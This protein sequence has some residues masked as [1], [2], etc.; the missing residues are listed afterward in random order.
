MEDWYFLTK[1]KY[2]T[3]LE[4]VWLLSIF[5]L[6]M[7]CVFYI[8]VIHDEDQILMLILYSLY[9]FASN[10]YCNRYR[11]HP[12]KIRPILDI[13][14]F[15]VMVTIKGHDFHIFYVGYY[16]EIRIF[17]TPIPNN[18]VIRDATCNRWDVEILFY[19]PTKTSI[20]KTSSFW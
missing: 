4:R 13:L 9:I 20:L 6:G 17:W 18:A 3:S 8:I 10:I 14:Q 19:L 5:A 7:C 11:E 16:S 2:F 1:L 15:L 12:R